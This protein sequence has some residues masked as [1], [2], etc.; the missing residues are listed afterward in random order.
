LEGKGSNFTFLL[1]IK[2]L[3]FE[4]APQVILP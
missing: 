3:E 2:T 1:P 4:A